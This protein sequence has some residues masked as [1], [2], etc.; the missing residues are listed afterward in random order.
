LGKR[1]LTQHRGKGGAQYRAPKKGKVA[2]LRYPLIQKSETV[3]GIVRSIVHERGRGYPLA[4]V[5]FGEK[6]ISY[7]PATE[8]L[9]VGSPVEMGKDAPPS[10]GNILPLS[11]I[12]EGSVISNIERYY[13]DGGRFVRTGGESAVLFAQTPQGAVIRLP[14]GK[15]SVINGDC[16]ATIGSVSGAGRT[17]RPFLRAGARFWAMKSK[18]KMYPRVRGIAMAVVHHPFGGGR[19]QH[20]GKS[21][22]T[23]KNAP[24]GRKVGHL[25]PRKTG[26]KRLARPSSEVG[27]V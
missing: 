14:S 1:I 11:K 9:E 2:I 6:R 5:E 17:E 19:H 20:P 18:N 24:P 12:P 26:R 22:S 4:K 7:I 16:R 21:T 3:K 27:K 8:G 23:S 15:T 25:G 10:V 13:G